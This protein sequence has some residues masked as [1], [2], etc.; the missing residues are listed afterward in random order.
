[1]TAT[2]QDN[3]TPDLGFEP[4]YSMTEVYRLEKVAKEWGVTRRIV[5]CFA[6]QSR[7]TLTETLRRI[8][9]SDG[10][11]EVADLLESIRGLIEFSGNLIKLY[12]AVEARIL[13]AA[14]DAFDVPW[15]DAARS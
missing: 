6:T 10:G 15:D 14:H 13:I 2:L 7:E 12:E 9:P 1:M 8:N 11:D 4:L 3:D 5:T